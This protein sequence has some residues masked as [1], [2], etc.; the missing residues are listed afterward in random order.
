M[1]I[2]MEYIIFRKKC[3]EDEKIG[4]CIYVEYLEV[5]ILLDGLLK[6]E[7]EG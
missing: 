2:Y 1:E 4:K 5:R 6:R 3:R 7:Y